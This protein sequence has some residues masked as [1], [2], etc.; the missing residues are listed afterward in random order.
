MEQTKTNDAMPDRIAESLA[1]RNII[2]TGG[3][4]FMGKVLFEKFLRCMPDIG[5]I[6]MLIRPK[7]GKDPKQR[8]DEIF[9]SV[10]R[11]R[12]TLFHEISEVRVEPESVIL[13]LLLRNS[14][15]NNNNS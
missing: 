9:N 11:P 1:G 13:L 5:H 14:N 7:K 15:N 10:V 4:G 3:T 12:L 8:L 6:Y 2:I